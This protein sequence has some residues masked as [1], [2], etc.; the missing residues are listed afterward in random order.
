MFLDIVLHH[1]RI[2][3][4]D[5]DFS[6]VEECLLISN[7]HLGVQSL[8]DIAVGRFCHRNDGAVIFFHVR[9][10]NIIDGDQPVEV[11]LFICDGQRE[12]ILPAHQCPRVFYGNTVLNSRHL[13]DFHVL[14]PGSDVIQKQRLIHMKI[15][16]HKLRFPVHLARPGGH[17][18]AA[19][20]HLVLQVSVGNG[21]ANRI[22][23]RVLVSRHANGS[24]FFHLL[25]C[26]IFSGHCLSS[27]FSISF[28]FSM[29]ICFTVL[30]AE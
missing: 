2:R 24:L 18:A 17:I 29:A 6:L 27:I 13:P 3:S 12:H 28:Y 1:I 15:I 10:G 16:Q 26:Q 21:R 25:P 11:I 8:Q 14:H 22:R 20:I 4:R 23:I 30:H 5:H 9:F 7:A 19:I